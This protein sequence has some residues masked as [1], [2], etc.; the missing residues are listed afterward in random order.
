V[1]AQLVLQDASIVLR[2]NF[3]PSMFH[4]SW[5]AATNLITTKEAEAASVEVIHPGVAIFRTEWLQFQAQGDRL[6]VE[7]ANE[8]YYEPLRDLAVGILQVLVSTPLTALGINRDFHYRLES[9]DQWHKV[10]HILAPKSHWEGLL[11]KP[12]ML[13]LTMQGQRVDA[14]TGHAQVKVQPSAKVQY[15][16]NINTNDHY[17]L[18]KGESTIQD[19]KLALSILATE[20]T[21][22]MRRSINIAEQIS[23]LGRPE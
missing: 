8:A 20:W 16:V 5:L 18:S 11:Q 7:T 3:N 12:G 6:Q 19:T 9:E 4:P 15:G 1:S 14:Y 13:S 22:S 17:Q 10:G 23:L 2:G 21:S